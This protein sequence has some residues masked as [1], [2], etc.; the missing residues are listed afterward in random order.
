MRSI[1]RIL[2][3]G[4]LLVALAGPAGA[5]GRDEL[6]RLRD[7]NATLRRELQE[8]RARLRELERR[9]GPGEGARGPDEARTLQVPELRLADDA[10]AADALE[11]AE[12]LLRG[13]QAL[14]DP[15]PPGAASELASRLGAYTPDPPGELLVPEPAWREAR[16]DQPRPG[17]GAL[18]ATLTE[19]LPLLRGA[20]WSGGPALGDPGPFLEVGLELRGAR[21]PVQLELEAVR[22]NGRLLLVRVRVP[23]FQ[24]HARAALE[25]ARRGLAS[26]VLRGEPVRLPAPGELAAD[27]VQELLWEDPRTLRLPGYR[28]RF[29]LPRRGEWGA[30]AEPLLP[31]E[32]PLQ[33][34]PLPGHDPRRDPYRVR[35]GR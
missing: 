11:L 21:G 7:E 34:G 9:A 26:Q 17:R 25:V 31:G 14:P 16:G 1:S 2:G 13:L 18:E 8:A 30:V 35:A 20:A 12:E 19:L 23:W 3:A 32:P 22:L 5:Q 4:L 15:P 6:R 29:E 24:A 27:G 28:V 33:V 10:G